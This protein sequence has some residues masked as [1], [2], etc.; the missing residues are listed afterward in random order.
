MQLEYTTYQSDLSA[1][2]THV[3]ILLHGYGSHA[4]DLITLAPEM[5]SYLPKSTLFVSAQA[6][7]PCE[8]GIPGGWQW[9]SLQD[10]LTEETALERARKPEKILNQFFQAVLE[11]Y[12]LTS[13][14]AAIVGFSQGSMMALHC[15]LRQPENWAAIIGY[16]GRLVGKASLINEVRSKPNICLIHGNEDLV[17]PPSCMDEAQQALQ[18]IGINAKTYLRP[19]LGHGIDLIGIKIGAEFIKKAFNN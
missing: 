9:F 11:E 6:P 14:N 8:A 16:S 17:V 4:Y 19:K 2:P 1:K 7:F 3:V 5:S 13:A 18:T 15:G 10:N 12:N